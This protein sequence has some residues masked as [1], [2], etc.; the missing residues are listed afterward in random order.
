MLG[1]QHIVNSLDRRVVRCSLKQIRI[2]ASL[3]G[4]L[5]HHIDEGIE[6][7]LA[8][9]LGGLNHQSLVKQQRE[10]NCWSMIA[11]VE[12]SLSHIHGGYAR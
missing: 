12:Q 5:V 7:F 9:V 3:V 8:L 10:I 11:I 2:S 1:C 6:R 4:N